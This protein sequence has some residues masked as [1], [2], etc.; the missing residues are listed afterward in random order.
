MSASEKLKALGRE[1]AMEHLGDPPVGTLIDVLPKIMAVVEAAEGMEGELPTDQ[2]CHD[3]LYCVEFR[4]ALSAL[5]EAL[6]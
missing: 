5:E 1:V 6:S 4:A 2:G 3:M